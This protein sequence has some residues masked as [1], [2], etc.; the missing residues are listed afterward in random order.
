MLEL[1]IKFINAVYGCQLLFSRCVHHSVYLSDL[2]IKDGPLSV[3]V[4]SV[5]IGILRP[6]MFW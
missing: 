3:C 5:S 2:S 1:F 4:A 6:G